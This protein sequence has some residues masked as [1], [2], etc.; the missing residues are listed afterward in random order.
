[1]GYWLLVAVVAKSFFVLSLQ[2]AKKRNSMT[3]RAVEN[4]KKK[5]EPVDEKQLSL[6]Q[7]RK[8]T[9][10]RMI[11]KVEANIAST[12]MTVE[13]AARS[14]PPSLLSIRDSHSHA[15]SAVDMPGHRR[16]SSFTQRKQS[17]VPPRA[18]VSGGQRKQS[19]RVA[20]KARK[21]STSKSQSR[22]K[23]THKASRNKSVAVKATPAR[24]RGTDLEE[25]DGEGDEEE[26]LEQDHSVA[27]VEYSM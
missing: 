14:M 27:D 2:E 11:E 15:L 22:K 8:Q 23:S 17:S 7:K 18:S 16:E 6:F 25:E 10:N 4:N 21:Q 5:N 12:E 9:L 20:P 19:T 3:S 24:G 26:E 13:E 1:M